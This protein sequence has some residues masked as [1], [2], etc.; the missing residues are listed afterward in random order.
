M[1]TVD[2]L[3]TVREAAAQLRIGKSEMY[4][5]VQTDEVSYIRIGV[6]I[7]RIPQSALDDYRDRHTKGGK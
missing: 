2:S 4:K 3:L 5:L 1:Q 7:I 6:K